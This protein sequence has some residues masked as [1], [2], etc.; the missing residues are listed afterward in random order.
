MTA[1]PQPRID[2][3]LR[4]LVLLAG[5]V[6]DHL[7]R[8]D[9]ET[10]LPAQDE[11]DEAFAQL[12]TLT[13]GGAM[14]EPRHVNELLRLH[15][16]HGDNERLARELHRAAGVELNNLSTLR[17]VNSAYAPLGANHRPSPR[18]VDGSA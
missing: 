2:L 5:E 8:G 14:L 6:H 15:H 18:Y 11:F 16:V 7:A 13:R 1:T 4:R 3:L 10:A 12:H 17:K 9:W